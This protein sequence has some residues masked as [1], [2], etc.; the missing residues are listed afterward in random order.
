VLVERVDDLAAIIPP[1]MQS[2][3]IGL[4][5]EMGQRI[6]RLPGGMTK[7]KQVL[8]LIQIAG[9]GVSAVIDPFRVNDLSRL[10]PLMTSTSTVKVVLG[11]ATDVQLLQDHDLPVRTVTD[12]GE[13]AVA[14]YGH[15][16]EGMQ[17]LAG[18]ALGVH[19][20]KSV[21]RENWLHRPVNPT[22]L[23]YAFRD[24]ELTLQLYRWFQT[25]HP[26]LVREYVRHELTPPPPEDLASWIRQFLIKRRDLVL[27]LQEEGI[28]PET[29]TD[30]LTADARLAL[31][32]DLTP[33]QR[34]R[35]L[36]AVG[37]LA[38]K[39]LY[40][41]VAALAA[42]SSGVFRAAAARALGRLET[43]AARPIL[44][45]LKNDP[46][47]D[48]RSSATMGLR[49]LTNGPKKKPAVVGESEEQAPALKPEAM[50]ALGTLL[51]Q[52]EPLP[53]AGASVQVAG[54]EEEDGG[55]H[56]I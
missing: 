32:A 51:Q 1:L 22:M 40:P 37:D 53:E 3:A 48:V 9:N 38:L 10:R 5:V 33:N 50:A 18:R 31:V 26:D 41:E 23:T 12:L 27:L 20:D 25:T 2:D 7:G 35:V 47:E 28:D 55:G 43:E 14:V 6:E 4:D 56:R 54:D 15:R 24:A 52:M 44:E 42:S 30:R 36:R 17:A 21:R 16:Q 46:L 13:M 11:G 49:D 39:D 34:R 45:E 19:I 29:E 8:A